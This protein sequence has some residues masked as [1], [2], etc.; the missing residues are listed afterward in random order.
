MKKLLSFLLV[1]T[2]VAFAFIPAMAEESFNIA[3]N[4]KTL[5]SEYW[6][7]VKA[8]CDRAAAELGVTIDVQ[9]AAAETEIAEQVAQLETQLA[10]NPDAI[11]IAPL[12]G[13]AVIG[14]ITSSGYQGI[15]VFCDTDCAYEAKTSFVG[16][17]NEDAAYAGGVYGGAINGQDTKAVIIY[18]QEGDNTS[19]LRKAGYEKALA[20]LGVEPV[21]MLSGNNT[22][23]GATKVM[24]DL[25]SAH[26]D[27]INLV[28]CHNDDTAIGALN[29]VEA[30]GVSGISILG[31]DGNQSAIELIAAGKLTGTVAQ[32]PELMGFLS[33]ET[34]LKALKGE[35]VEKT[36]SVATV[37]IDAANH[38]EYLK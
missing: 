38:A 31:F 30:A 18:G 27:G 1:L 16:T 4:L 2:L 12:D 15:V 13:D 5:S 21:A 32:Q 22:T 25:L 11:I 14:A 7:T 37:I 35:E 26:P 10:G 34:A 23:D 3:I 20:E 28:L 24:E 6:Q 17:S 19:N 9:G 8:G 33:V 29:A 36:V